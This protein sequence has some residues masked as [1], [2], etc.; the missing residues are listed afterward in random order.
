[1]ALLTTNAH[2]SIALSPRAASDFAKPELTQEQLSRAIQDTEVAMVEL[3]KA[4]HVLEEEVVKKIE[5]GPAGLAQLSPARMAPLQSQV[6]DAT[7]TDQARGSRVPPS[8]R[9]ARP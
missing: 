5:M 8:S 4:Q 7:Q 1:M 3:A 6:H 2:R 9:R